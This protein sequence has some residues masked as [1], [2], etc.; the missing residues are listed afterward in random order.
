M[1]HLQAATP[2]S[3]GPTI[4]G[5]DEERREG[6]S[7]V[8]FREPWSVDVIVIKTEQVCGAVG[9]THSSKTDNVWVVLSM[10]GGLCGEYNNIPTDVFHFGGAQCARSKSHSAESIITCICGYHRRYREE[11]NRA[12][13]G[14]STRSCSTSS[15]LVCAAGVLVKSSLSLTHMH[16]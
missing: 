7:S 15:K 1:T 2:A 4:E 14:L 9:N 12:S 10:S 11:S 3:T 5:A 6:Q 8:W 13:T 16:A